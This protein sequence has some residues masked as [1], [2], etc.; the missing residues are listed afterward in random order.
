MTKRRALD[1]CRREV[2]DSRARPTLA[3]EP[4]GDSVFIVWPSIDRRLP[5]RSVICDM[6]CFYA[7]PMV[8]SDLMQPF[9]FDES[10]WLA[11][12]LADQLAENSSIEWSTSCAPGNQRRTGTDGR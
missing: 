10:A 3:D 6:L 5:P 12:Q 9:A 7:T 11:G 8:R 1:R 2:D 4:I